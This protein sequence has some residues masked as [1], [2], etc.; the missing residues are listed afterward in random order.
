MLPTNDSFNAKKHYLEEKKKEK[1]KKEENP[2]ITI[3][4]FLETLPVSRTLC[5]VLPGVLFQ[6]FGSNY[7]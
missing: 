7:E 4:Q 6:A 3:L 5:Y 2:E 1:K